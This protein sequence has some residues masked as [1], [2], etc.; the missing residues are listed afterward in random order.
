MHADAVQYA[1]DVLADIL[2]NIANANVEQLLAQAEA[3]LEGIK[4][5]NF[6]D[7]EN[8]AQDELRDAEDRELQN[9]TKLERFES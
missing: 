2:N 4:N 9:T 8:R 7:Y 6:N 1:N 5:R 3:I